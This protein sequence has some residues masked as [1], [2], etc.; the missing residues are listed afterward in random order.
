MK[1]IKKIM[2][3]QV[4]ATPWPGAGS[5]GTSIQ[6]GAVDFDFIFQRPAVCHDQLF[7][8]QM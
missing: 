6:P 7:R 4:A 5:Q 3:L 2:E 1:I 8:Y